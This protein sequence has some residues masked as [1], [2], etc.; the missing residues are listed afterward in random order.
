ML[1]QTKVALDAAVS[2]RMVS[3]MTQLD[4]RMR[5]QSLAVQGTQAAIV[6]LEDG[7][8]KADTAQQDLLK[9]EKPRKGG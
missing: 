7:I 9:A 3:L 6:E 1:G 4:A 5:R 8:A 2:Q